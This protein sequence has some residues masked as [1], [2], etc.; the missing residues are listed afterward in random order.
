MKIH[1][2]GFLTKSITESL[3]EFEALG[4]SKKGGQVTDESRKVNIQF[5]ESE[6]GH[7]I[8]LISPVNSQSVV[9][10]LMK[11]F[12]NQVYHICYQVAEI[13]TAIKKLQTQ[14]FMV[15]EPPKY[16]PALHCHVA[17]LYAQYTGIIELMDKK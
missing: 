14:G 11:K 5:I 13:N 2:Y 16:A 6:N 9:Y 1:H 4:Y 10:G 8:E 3:N 15:I 12:K 7:C 17:F